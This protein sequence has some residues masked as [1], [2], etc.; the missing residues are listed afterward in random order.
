MLRWK[1]EPNL[2]LHQM[3]HPGERDLRDRISAALCWRFSDSP[4]LDDFT[5]K[6]NPYTSK[7]SESVFC[8][9]PWIPLK[10]SIY[11][12]A[13]RGRKRLS[14]AAADA[15]APAV[16]AAAPSRMVRTNTR[17][18]KKTY[19]NIRG[20]KRPRGKPG[21]LIIHYAVFELFSTRQSTHWG[22]QP[23]VF[24]ALK[25][26]ASFPQSLV[27]YGVHSPQVPSNALA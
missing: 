20:V 23:G 16:A 11:C 9:S 3:L 14:V 12:Q 21:F 6:L 24:R 15:N 4:S 22:R 18:L 13:A 26:C 5:S 10:T 2:H 1:K 19:R 17:S 8:E 25:L 7:L 27:L